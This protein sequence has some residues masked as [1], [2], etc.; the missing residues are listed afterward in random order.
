MKL[1]AYSYRRWSSD[2]QTSGDSLTRQTKS[3]RAFCESRGWELNESLSPDE[4]VSAYRGSNF[5]K[6]SLGKFLDGVK[7]G[8]VK[9]PCA[10]MIDDM[11]RFSRLPFK[12]NKRHVE[13]LLESG[14]SLAT[15][16]DGA[17]YDA[18]SLDSAFGCMP[19]LMKIE[20]AHNY[21]K[22]LGRKVASARKR[23][24]QEAASDKR[25]RWTKICPAWLT[26][27]KTKNEFIV[28]EKI[29]AIVRQIFRDY[30]NGKGIRRIT[31]ELNEN[32]VPASRSKRGWSPVHVR[33][34]L[35]NRAVLGEYQPMTG[36]GNGEKKTAG[37]PILNYYPTII[38]KSLFY[39]A[40]DKLKQNKRLSGP[41]KGGTNLFTGLMKCVHCGSSMFYKYDGNR[42]K[43]Y[44]ANLIC[45]KAW[46]GGKCEKRRIRYSIVERGI[47]TVLWSKVVPQMGETDNRAEAVI[48]LQGELAD[49]KA[50]ARQAQADYHETPSNAVAQALA[51]FEAQAD[52]LAKQ[53][54]VATAKLEESP[55][56]G[57]KRVEPTP[58]NRIRLGSNLANE[59][60][61]INVDAGK[62]TAE[63][64]MNDGKNFGLK[65]QPKL[66]NAAKKDPSALGF[67]L[68]GAGVK[69]EPIAYTDHFTV[70]K[71]D[72][73]I[74]VEVDENG[75]VGVIQYNAA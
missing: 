50:K 66:S 12:E 26:L 2:K 47:L 17:V 21:S 48:K 60:K 11:S 62:H 45:S 15:V 57:W 10:L 25:I 41:R 58:D 44:L 64:E 24:R 40:Q 71:S 37:D 35:T 39:Q 18:N 31:I 36:T 75:M 59:I 6:G 29:A 49:V 69:N 5:V 68:T 67:F 56:T 72:K 74:E 43:G 38:E 3:I 55:L 8:R 28:I 54:E 53:I 34:I 19:I 4:G 51:R 61:A 63:L 22:E 46:M 20:A 52:D 30:V 1:V 73:P 32:K 42:K 23:N 16:N 13:S 27:D 70:W 14:V 7:S 9:V 33:R 65:W